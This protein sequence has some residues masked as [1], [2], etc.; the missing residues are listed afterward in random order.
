MK[1]LLWMGLLLSTV[2]ITSGCA[3]T[4]PKQT[5]N[6]NSA[7][8]SITIATPPSVREVNVH[9]QEHPG[10]TF[11][12]VGAPLLGFVGGMVAAADMQ[13]KTTRYNATIG[14]INW[15]DYAQKQLITALQQA[16][17]QTH[18]SNARP[19]NNFHATFL[20]EPPHHQGDALLDYYFN[21]AHF[22]PN[23]EADYIPTINLDVRLTDAKT[24]AILYAKQ[25]S[26]GHAHDQART[27]IPI[28]QRFADSRTLQTQRHASTAALK[29]GITLIAQRIADDLNKQ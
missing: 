2:L 27:H 20:R 1:L 21:L 22:A 11:D 7:I 17:Y 14:K 13:L 4:L 16:G 23:A 8:K 25:F 10:R 12:A 9:M 19:L 29:Q 24:Q 5:F 6:K 18:T 15:R 26:V 3:N 28:A